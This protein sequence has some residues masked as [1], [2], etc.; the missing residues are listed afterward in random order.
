[1]NN[2]GAAAVGKGIRSMYGKLGQEGFKPGDEFIVAI[3]E[4][5]KQGAAIILGDQDVDVTL[6]RMAQALQKKRPQPIAQSRFRIGTIHAR[7]ATH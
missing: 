7:N 4:G 2:L 5:Q 1:M 6:R 3:K